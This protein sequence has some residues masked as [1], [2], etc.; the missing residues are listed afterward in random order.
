MS[1]LFVYPGFLHADADGL[2]EVFFACTAHA[3]PVLGRANDMEQKGQRQNRATRIIVR[4]KKKLNG[5]CGTAVRTR[6]GW[7]G[8]GQLLL[9]SIALASNPAEAP[10]R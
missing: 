5:T 10:S 1:S 8:H 4:S 6:D 2:A 9:E 7:V 3:V